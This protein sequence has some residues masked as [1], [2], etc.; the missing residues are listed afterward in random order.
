MQRFDRPLLAGQIGGLNIRCGSGPA[1]QSAELVARNLPVGLGCHTADV[2]LDRVS[3]HSCRSAIETSRF[4]AGKR[5]ANWSRARHFLPS[6]IAG[7][8]AHA[9]RISRCAGTLLRKPW[10]SAASVIVAAID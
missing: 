2:R 7:F 5:T 9:A 6:G 1:N 3:T 8:E 10:R 4:T